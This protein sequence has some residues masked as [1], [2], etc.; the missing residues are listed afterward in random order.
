[1]ILQTFKNI[2][3]SQDSILINN[4]LKSTE[5][6][7]L[8]VSIVNRSAPEIRNFMAHLSL[9]YLILLYGARRKPFQ[10]Y[11]L[12]VFFS[13]QNKKYK[14]EKIFDAKHK[15]VK[16]RYFKSNHGIVVW[17][18]SICAALAYACITNYS[19]HIV[20]YH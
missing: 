6:K 10:S 4:V 18:I 12:K 14:N 2:R 13:L 9:I 17:K 11:L 8:S 3:Y 15:K 20:P 5:L 16:Q 1:M 7:F 19:N